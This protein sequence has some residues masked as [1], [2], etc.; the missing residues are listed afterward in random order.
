M[1]PISQPP[2]KLL[3]VGEAYGS[4]E[5]LRSTQRKKPSPFVG[6]A[7][8]FL[9]DLLGLA[10]ILP[11]A[12]TYYPGRLGMEAEWDQAADAGI[13]LTNTFNLRPGPDSNELDLLLG[14]KNKHE[15]EELCLDLPALRP[16]KYL[17]AKYRSELDR[18]QEEIATLNPH[19]VL[20][21]GATATWALLKNKSISRTRGTVS[22]LDGRKVLPT[23]H[24]SAILQGRN[25]WKPI[26]L[27][28]LLKARKEMQDPS[29][30]RLDRTIYIP[31]TPEDIETW[32]QAYGSSA[33]LLS[34]DIETEKNSWISEI[35][36]AASKTNAIWIPFL[37]KDGKFLR[38]YWPDTKT[39]ASAWLLTKK[40]LEAK[41]PIVGQN[42]GG[43]DLHYLLKKSPVPSCILPRCYANDTMIQQH[44]LFPGMK[45]DLGFLASIYCNELAWKDIRGTTGKSDDRSEA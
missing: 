43:Y 33:P 26:V 15:P 17:F 38:S 30:V 20:C 25:E 44:C 4:D 2:C 6:R 10:R 45:K 11:P 9:R 29:F 13:F 35:G 32:W 8:F 7:G 34:V 24:P 18:L 36:V 39:E 40:I 31:E 12:P 14:A 37:L 3:I 27:A 5:L 1:L 16:G 21:L 28:D 23:Y 41:K 22:L 42:F 19:L